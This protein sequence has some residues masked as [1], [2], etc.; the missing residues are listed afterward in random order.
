[1]RSVFLSSIFGPKLSKEKYDKLVALSPKRYRIRDR[2]GET[3]KSRWEAQNC[4][5]VSFPFRESVRSIFE[6]E[7]GI[8]L[9]EWKSGSWGA[10]VGK[11]HDEAI[12]NFDEKYLRRVFLRTLFD[13]AIA[14]DLLT[15][16]PTE[17]RTKAGEHFNSAKYEQSVRSID[18]IAQKMSDFIRSTPGFMAADTIV[19]V[20][21]SP[22]KT[23]D[24]PS[25]LAKRIATITKKKLAA[26]CIF[27]SGTKE[28]PL[29]EV[30]QAAKWDVLER[31]G[32]EFKKSALG[33]CILIDDLYQS[34]TTVHFWG[35]H[36]ERAGAESVNLLC[37]VK[38]NRD[39]DNI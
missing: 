3:V 30:A 34:G 9:K 31:A 2:N 21:P 11:G 36:L 27:P 8:K 12:R 33:S 17:P 26:D 38:S 16:S 22:E 24:L 20:P 29:K 15:P 25:E 10:K 1:M 4:D 14:L 18:L 32:G 28:R 6:S 13:H 39:T 5:I 23:F 19:P 7:T 35:S 37:C